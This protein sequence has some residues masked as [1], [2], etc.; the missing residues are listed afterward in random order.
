M[1]FAI[2]KIL[3]GSASLEEFF[4][5]AEKLKFD[6]V[7]FGYEESF[8][9]YPVASD[10]RK[11]LAD[12]ALKWAGSYWGADWHV[13]GLRESFIE[14]AQKR[15][16]YMLEAGCNT[17]IIGPPAR[18]K[19]Y[20]EKK[21]E[22]L[23]KTCVTI[24]AIGKVASNMGLRVGIHNHYGTTI[25][26]SEEIDYVMQHTDAG[27]VGFCPD[28]A[29]LAVSGCDALNVVKRYVDRVVY[30]HLKDAIKPGEFVPRNEKWDERL[31]DLGKGQ[32]PLKEILKS[33]KSH[34]YEGWISYEQDHPQRGETAEESASASKKYIELELKNL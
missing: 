22:Y 3:F 21:N 23:E 13:E 26:S 28:T 25:E 1:K 7:E 32:I 2:C 8:K 6:G 24:N 19:G 5:V 11:A 14:Q 12:K 10:L 29:H 15:A 4:G 9:R 16:K 34:G 18:F 31:R 30:L 20:E 17:I 27:L 33:L